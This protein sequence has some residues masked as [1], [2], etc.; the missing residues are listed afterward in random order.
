M[1]LLA[2]ASL[3]IVLL[4]A[5]T[6]GLAVMVDGRFHAWHS[7]GGKTGSL[8]VVLTAVAA[9]LWSGDRTARLYALLLV[10]FY[11]LQAVW[12]LAGQ[13]EAL[14]WMRALHVPTALFVFQFAWLLYGKSASR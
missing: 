9:W 14:H 4:Q 10:V 6:A 2:A 1:R 7:L 5:S 3:L 12:L 8:V 13:V 11:H